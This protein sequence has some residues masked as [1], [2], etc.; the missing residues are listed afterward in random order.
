VR[1][2]RGAF[3]A[4]CAVLLSLVALTLQPLPSGAAAGSPGWDLDVAVRVDDR[5]GTFG[6]ALPT[7]IVA[8]GL[9]AGRAALATGVCA[10]NAGKG[11]GRLLVSIIDSSE[12]ET[13]CSG[14]ERAVDATCGLGRGELGEALLVVAG[15]QERC[16]GP[17][18]PAFEASLASLTALPRDLGVE[19]RGG[20]TT[21][22]ALG[23]WYRA[24]PPDLVT[25][26]Q[27]DRVTWRFAL[28]LVGG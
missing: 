6:E 28:D 26:S 23:L 3:A 17:V 13:G 18:E 5:C 22:L 12:S 14:D 1:R 7:L 20:Q 24:G 16:R 10:R 11:T 21:C 27:T 2:L 8:D 9:Q 25:A 19:L 15:R 4:S